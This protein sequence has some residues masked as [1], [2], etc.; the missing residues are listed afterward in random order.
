MDYFVTKCIDTK[1]DYSSHIWAE[2]SSGSERSFTNA[3]ESL[4]SF[5]T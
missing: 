1:S 4:I 2:M 3:N 5:K